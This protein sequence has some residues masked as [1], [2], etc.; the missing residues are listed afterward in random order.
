MKKGVILHCS[1]SDFGSAMEID[2][3]HKNQGW[4]SVGYHFVICN[5]RVESNHYYPSLDGMIERGRSIDMAGA[6]A[7][8]FNTSHIG[9]CLIG[10]KSFS[11]KQFESLAIL[12]KELK[13]KFNLN[14]DDII[15]HCKVSNKT[16]PNFDV[17]SF[18]REYL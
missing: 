18:K 7:Q 16:C 9:I 10:N 11:K 3:W 2:K 4:D 13:A 15:G 6:H 5:G 12:L 17:D 8:G 14:N 1:A